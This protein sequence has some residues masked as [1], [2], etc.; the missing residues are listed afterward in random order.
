MY[1]TFSEPPPRFQ[2]TSTWPEPKSRLKLPPPKPFKQNSKLGLEEGRLLWKLS[3][4]NLLG[5]K[6]KSRKS[7]G[8]AEDVIDEDKEEDVEETP[9]QAEEPHAHRTTTPLP[10][11]GIAVPLRVL[12]GGLF[13]TTVAGAVCMFFVQFPILR[14]LFHSHVLNIIF[15]FSFGFLYIATL[16]CMAYCTFSEPGQLEFVPS[17]LPDR[18]HK[19]WLYERPIQRYDHYCRWLMN[20]IGLLNH[21]E[22]MIMLIGLVAISVA[23]ACLDVVLV[24]VEVFAGG[25]LA[26]V[27]IFLHLLYSLTKARFVGEIL[28]MHVGFVSRNELCREWKEDTFWRVHSTT[29]FEGKMLK[30]FDAEELSMFE[31]G[32]KLDGML[33]SELSVDTYNAMDPET[34]RY[35]PS[36]NPYDLGWSSNCLAFW[37][38]PRW[39]GQSQ[40]VF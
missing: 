21:R 29:V 36:L 20:C 40:T 24:I 14:D 13:V 30:D 25:W 28:S 37:W 1:S 10:I 2:P 17:K 34:N 4:K 16:I 18:A 8:V 39:T 38:T 7:L 11:I 23:G 5:G 33:V 32:D 9:E 6:T 19:T 31:E 26:A 15:A 3:S 35:D 22:F 27:A 12:P